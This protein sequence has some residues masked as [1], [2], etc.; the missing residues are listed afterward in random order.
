MDLPAADGTPGSG[1]CPD[2]GTAIDVTPALARRSV[3]ELLERAGISL[4]SVPAAEALMVTTELVTNAL[5]HGG[6]LTL[7][8]IAVTDNA[9]HLSVGDASTHAPVFRPITLGQLGG[10]GWPLI[11][12][13]TEHLTVR[14]L[15]EGKIIEAVLP[16][17]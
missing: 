5:R 12:R 11:Q 3:G 16:L 7:F 1:R 9:L 4:D 13:L 14:L 17:A 10:Y 8:R 2:S 15:P 6:G